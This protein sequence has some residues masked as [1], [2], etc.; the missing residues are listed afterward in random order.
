MF[1]VLRGA[2][3]VAATLTMGLLAGLFYAFAVSVMPGLARTDGRSFVDAMQRI[4]M[5]ITNPWFFLSFFGAPV[6][7][8]AAAALHLRGAGRAVLPWIAAHLGPRPAGARACSLEPERGKTA[9]CR[10][11]LEAERGYPAG[12]GWRRTAPTPRQV[13]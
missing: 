8:I 12:V 13:R 6:L 9:A 4:N 7:T 5:A 3:L 1:G 11:S 10:C 2:T